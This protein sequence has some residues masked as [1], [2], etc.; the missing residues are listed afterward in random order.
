M[1]VRNIPIA[2]CIVF[3]AVAVLPTCRKRENMWLFL[4]SF[5]VLAPANLN[6]VSHGYENLAMLLYYGKHTW[7]SKVLVTVIGYVILTSVEQLLIGMIGRIIWR[8]QYRIFSAVLKD[9]D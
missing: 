7:L 6:A 4:L 8:R 9:Y 1:D 3:G 2:L 5:I